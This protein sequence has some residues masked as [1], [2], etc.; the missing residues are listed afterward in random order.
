VPPL[1][2]SKA[3]DDLLCENFSRLSDLCGMLRPVG[4]GL[5]SDS[6]DELYL[7][8]SNRF[9]DWPNPKVPAVAAGVYTIWDAKQFIYVGMSGRWL[10]AVDID[11]PDQPVNAR[12][13]KARLDSHA[14][15]RRSGDQFC[16]YICDRFVVPRLDVDQQAQIGEGILLLD[17]LTRQYIH[18]RLAY[19]FKVMTDG[20]MALAL[21]REI[22]RG[23]LPP[24]KPFLNPL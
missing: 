8:P 12:G 4:L 6:H 13:L 5:Y 11:P 19:R 14:R 21:E 18:D 3:T 9:A 16:V 1:P 15:G 24:G 22:Q 10:T 23:K 2:F 20:A 7:G 17:K